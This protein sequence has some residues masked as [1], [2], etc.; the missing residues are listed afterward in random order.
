MASV[1]EKN[2]TKPQLDASADAEAWQSALELCGDAIREGTRPPKN[3][4]A[5]EQQVVARSY[6]IKQAGKLLGVDGETLRSATQEL[7]L[8]SFLDPRGKLRFPARTLQPTAADP[9]L[10][11]MIAGYARLRPADL[12]AALA[13]D[14][15]T[16]HNRIRQAG[17][18]PKRIVWR[19]ARGLWGL[20]QTFGEY[21]QLLS[22]KQPSAGSGKG[23]SRRS[24]HRKRRQREAR[25]KLR[26]RLIDAFPNWRNDW[27]E[28]QQLTLHIGVPNSGKTHDAL[29]A[30][31]L[32]GSGWYL[33]PL[34]LLAYEIFDR[35]NAEGVPCSLLTGEEVI[36]V[37]G[38]KI[39]AAT[40]EMFNAHD[41][42]ECVIIDE[43]QMLADA[44]RGWAWTRALMECAAPDMH[45]IGPPT[46]RKLIEVLAAAA[47]LPCE[48]VEHERLAPIAVAERHF[49]LEALPPATILVAFSRRNVL[50]LKM[51]LERMGRA[52]SVVYGSLPPEVRRRQ[53]D[54]FAEGETEICIATDAVGMGLNL[55]ADVV[56]FYE[57]EKYDGKSDRRLYPAEVHQIGG[58]AG[59]YGIREAGLIAATTKADMDIIRE[60]YAQQ[61]PELSY[62]RVAP[63]VDDLTLIPGSL[64]EQLTRWA[65]L[66]SIPDE[67]RAIIT[68]ADMDERIE[69]AKMLTD[70]E[71]KRLGLARALQ[72]VN[73]PT[74]KST[75]A[76]WLDCAY[77]IIEGYQMPMPPAAP[78]PIQDAGDLD[79]T[80]ACIA[81][82]D[83]YLWLSQRKEFANFGEAHHQVREERRE[84]S[85]SIDQVLLLNLNTARRCRVC[86]ARLPS[87]HRYRI[88]EDCYQRRRHRAA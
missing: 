16:L 63:T 5:L 20:P 2:K 7:A 79:A 46:A 36:Q 8:D 3:K 56:C 61:P 66:K 78:V 43:A 88:C 13:V 27:R 73:A 87:R 24:R 55:P 23:K 69:L 49:A 81:C 26:S 70:D 58:R 85:L 86:R 52:V 48:L 57:T 15:R 42:G 65:E 60:L 25:S 84:W 10:R 53:A 64:A 59:R 41:S 28:Q 37:E 47:E 11:E 82:A 74:R 54:R 21:S 9:D 31:K 4:Q 76:Y 71:I 83:V 45:I 39:T 80:E 32:A 38:A 51:T 17:L 6:T 19:D 1:R 30:L 75:R 68:T 62:A 72:L 18:S 50:D 12:R 34:R 67:L 29:Q 14:L 40:I 35:L 77:M 22:E 33:A 44:D